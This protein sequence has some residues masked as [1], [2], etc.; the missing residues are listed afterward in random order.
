[1]NKVKAYNKTQ[2]GHRVVKAK[3]QEMPIWKADLPEHWFG[4]L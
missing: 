2:F 1:M 3:L 4:F